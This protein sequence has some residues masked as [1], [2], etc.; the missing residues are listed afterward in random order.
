MYKYNHKKNEANDILCTN[1]TTSKIQ[2]NDILSTN[3][4][5]FKS[6]TY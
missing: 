4:D 3:N 6:M 1:T 2:N 5:K